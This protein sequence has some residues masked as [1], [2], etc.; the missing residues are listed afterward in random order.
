MRLKLRH[1]SQPSEPYVRGLG[2]AS[3]RP[4]ER[5]WDN[6]ACCSE[7]RNT[8]TR[9]KC[10]LFVLSVLC[11]GREWNDGAC[12]QRS[13]HLT[14]YVIRCT[15]EYRQGLHPNSPPCVQT[16]FSSDHYSR[17]NATMPE[18]IALI[19]RVPTRT[20]CSHIRG[21]TRTSLRGQTLLRRYIALDWKHRGHYAATRHCTEEVL[22]CKPHSGAMS[23]RQGYLVGR[24]SKKDTT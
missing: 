15:S 9:M 6:I 20:M 23:Y 13:M 17:Q 19:C 3:I 11:S 24:V 14:G 8:K 16:S 12:Q 7:A 21:E 4:M 5:Q 1:Q 2:N 22:R 10:L 18:T